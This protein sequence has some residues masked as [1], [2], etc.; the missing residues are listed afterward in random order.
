MEA[1]ND[2]PMGEK[3]MTDEER[4][5]LC[6]DLRYMYNEWYCDHCDLEPCDEAADEIE[7][8]A[9]E[10]QYQYA[11]DKAQQKEIERLAQELKDEK[12]KPKLRFRQEEPRPLIIED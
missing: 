2:W 10:L 12:R 1:E 7:R 8:L 11:C 5:K 3:I 6:A 9:E 4:K